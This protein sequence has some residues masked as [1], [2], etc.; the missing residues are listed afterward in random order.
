MVRSTHTNVTD[1]ANSHRNFYFQFTFVAFVGISRQAMRVA[2]G[3]EVRPGIQ[4][5]LPDVVEGGFCQL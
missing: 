5:D 3:F 4:A 2:S 1:D